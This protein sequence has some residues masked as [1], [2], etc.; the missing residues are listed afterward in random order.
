[1]TNREL[2]ALMLLSFGGVMLVVGVA[3]WAGWAAGLAVAGA[4]VLTV[5]V[6][7]G[8][9]PAPAERDTAP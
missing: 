5:G 4:V 6:L 7:L 1:V 8:T 3:F 2:A 9:D